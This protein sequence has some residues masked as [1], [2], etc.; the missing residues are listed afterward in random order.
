MSIVKIDKGGQIYIPA[1]LRKELGFK[2]GDYLNLEVN[3]K[4]RMIV[5]RPE[6][7]PDRNESINSLK[8]ILAEVHNQTK[9]IPSEIIEQEIEEA[10]REVRSKKNRVKSSL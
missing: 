3:M 2:E 5:L 9:N 7:K 1:K 4:D 6:L 8:M 10:I